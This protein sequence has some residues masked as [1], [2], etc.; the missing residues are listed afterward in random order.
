MSKCITLSH[1]C[2]NI[3]ICIIYRIH[4]RVVDVNATQVLLKLVFVA[5]Q[6][7]NTRQLLFPVCYLTGTINR[8]R[9]NRKF[10]SSYKL[11]RALSLP[12]VRIMQEE[13][14]RDTLHIETNSFR[15]NIFSLLKHFYDSICI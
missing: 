14:L 7:W 11:Y 5:F 3:I 4:A 10:I 2:L 1:T 13:I 12:K 6:T 15:K 9:E 8:A